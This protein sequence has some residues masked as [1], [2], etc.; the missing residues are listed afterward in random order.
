MRKLL[1]LTCALML[2]SSMAFAKRIP[3][4]ASSKTPADL[5]PFPDAGKGWVTLDIG[6]NG[7]VFKPA[8][9]GQEKVKTRNTSV[10]PSVIYAF[11]SNIAA[12]FDIGFVTGKAP[13]VEGDAKNKVT[14]ITNPTIGVVYRV[15][16]SAKNGNDL[17]IGLSVSPTFGKKVLKKKSNANAVQKSNAISGQNVIA[18]DV[19]W[20]K[21]ISDFVIGAEFGFTYKGQQKVK[22]KDQDPVEVDKYKATRD[23]NLGINA[24]YKGV[25]KLVLTTG[26]DYTKYGKLKEKGAVGVAYKSF[27]QFALGLGANYNV[28]KNTYLG[29]NWDHAFKATVKD[30]DGK[31][32][33]VSGDSFGIGAT[34]Q[35]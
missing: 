19:A 4:S 35:F 9:Q 34:Y 2:V 24:Q 28:C 7:N 21:N 26:I 23:I 33:K 27:G 3:A 25:N 8:A 14:G 30:N 12:T 6:S 11:N 5:V 31:L 10:T 32:G 17:N 16:D 1:T 29:V 15:L 22:D 13:S 20:S 18:F